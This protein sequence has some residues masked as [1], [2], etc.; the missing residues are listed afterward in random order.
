MGAESWIRNSGR[1]RM[2]VGL[3]GSNR[4]FTPLSLY[5]VLPDLL[6]QLCNI[7]GRGCGTSARKTTPCCL[8]WPG[9]CSCSLSY[10]NNNIIW[11]IGD[12]TWK[13]KKVQL[14]LV[15]VK[16]WPKSSFFAIYYQDHDCTMLY[17]T[18]K[19]IQ[20]REFEI[21]RY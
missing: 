21:C 2:T 1:Y 15:Y 20:D 19:Q 12:S 13:Y 18:L 14:L 3:E 5:F 10:K 8:S 16:Y 17:Q 7:L 4:N 11:I 6:M 9:G